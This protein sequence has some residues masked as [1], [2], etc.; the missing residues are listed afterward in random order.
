MDKAF[1]LRRR[2]QVIQKNIVGLFLFV[3]FLNSQ[4]T[5]AQQT[6]GLFKKEEGSLDGT[7]LFSPLGNR[8][9]YLIDKCGRTINTWSSQ[10]IPGF[11]V[12]LL[13]DGTLLRTGHLANNYFSVG[14]IGGVIEKYDWNNNLLWSYTLSDSIHCMHHDICPL[15]NGNILAI[16]YKKVKKEIA[17]ENGKNPDLIP[18]EIWSDKIIEL[19]PVGNDSAIVVWEWDAWDHIIQD[20]DSSK[21]N[22]GMVNEH[23]ELIDINFDPG[24]QVGADW[25]HANAV[26][27][28][29][30]LDQIIITIHNYSEVW[31][32][33]HSTTTEE[34][35]SHSG[36]NS[37]KGGDL[38]YRWGNPEAYK[39]GGSNDRTLYFP[40]NAH[41]IEQ[42]LPDENS[43]IIFNNGLLRPQGNFSTIEV[44]SP[45][46]DSIGNYTISQ[47]E[48]FLPT[49][50]SWTYMDS[51]PENFY[52]AKISGVQRLSNGNTL[53][54][55]GFKGHFFEVDSL[56]NTVWDYI[57]PAMID[58]IANQGDPI[59]LYSNSVFRCTFYPY[60][61]SGFEGKDLTS[62]APIELNPTPNVCDNIQGLPDYITVGNPEITVFP[63]PFTNELY[64]QSEVIL[65]SIRI[66]VYNVFGKLV[67]S[68]N[69]AQ[70]G[71]KDF[72]QL[73]LPEN[74]NPD[75]YYIKIYNN[76]FL[77]STKVIRK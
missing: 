43:I 68:I 36:G 45:P 28:N 50:S 38:L 64:I 20:L 8:S 69:N 40:H 4:F 31:V 63:N 55:E 67:Y 46:I 71:M 2:I 44:L 11:S 21:L 7:I 35:A 33:D 70:L 1:N 10:Y 12:Y 51:I 54:C 61:Y 19:Q 48:S 49:S 5:F 13:E 57:N 27:Y 30:L 32:I 47:S 39:R 15:P 23:P 56:N 14:F 52:S 26:A 41:W 25:L 42:D 34:S 59:S 75:I 9:T 76:N 22:S 60:D 17:I 66:E 24:L 16:V 73:L 72:Y 77:F 37:R 18:P 58:G 65:K 62:G 74:L 6:V 53:I 29:P 3:Y